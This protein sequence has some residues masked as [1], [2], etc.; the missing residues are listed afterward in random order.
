LIA[1]PKKLKKRLINHVTHG[2]DGTSCERVWI[3]ELALGMASTSEPDGIPTIL[4]INRALM[5]GR[6][7]SW[8]NES[9]EACWLTPEKYV[10]FRRLAKKQGAKG[11]I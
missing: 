1:V 6:G 4:E 3:V 10:Q 9:W 11:I 7:G 5:T 8:F 2:P